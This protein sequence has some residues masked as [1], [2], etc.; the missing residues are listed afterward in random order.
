MITAKN[1]SYSSLQA[2]CNPFSCILNYFVSQNKPDQNVVVEVD[3]ELK[4]KTDPELLLQDR[5]QSTTEVLSSSGSDLSPI[6]CA[7]IKKES[8]YL[9]ELENESAPKSSRSDV[10]SRVSN[11]IL[12]DGG[13]FEKNAKTPVISSVFTTNIFNFLGH[14]ILDNSFS[15][16]VKPPGQKYSTQSI[17]T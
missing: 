4:P 16:L 8:R 3:V 15:S 13:N 5:K 12:E 11:T 14:R 9:A 10:E 7:R 2:S 17:S 1:P 6:Q